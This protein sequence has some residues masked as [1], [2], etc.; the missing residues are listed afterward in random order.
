MDAGDTI[1]LDAASTGPLPAR[2]VAA[3]TEFTRR[4][5]TPHLISYEDQFQTLDRCRA[6]IARLIGAATDEIALAPNTGAGINLAAWGLPLGPGDEVVVPDGEFPANMYPWL[7]AARARGFSVVVVPQRDGLL[8]E[9]ALVAALDRPSVR[10]LAVSWVSFATGFAADLDHLGHACRARGV[11]L[12]VDAIQGLGAL[13]LDVTRT[14]IDLLACGAQKWLLSPWGT[15][16]IWMRRDLL[17]RI[18]PQPVSWMAVRSADDFSRL[19]D[20][21]LTWRDSAR[22]FE[23]VTMAYQ[24][25]AGMA[26]SLEL[27][28]E[29]GSRAVAKQVN[30]SAR[31]LIEGAGAVG[32]PVITPLERSA[33]IAS[34]RPSNPAGASAALR[35][36]G[37]IHSLREGTL[38]LAPHAFTSDEDIRTT[39]TMLHRHGA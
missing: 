3:E 30:R 14:P 28:H 21:D 38:R 12:V 26:A 18:I 17:A 4:R 23:Q 22:R 25:F 24:A 33:G 36:S 1:Y 37:V 15:G 7:A 20:Y 19:L 34:I 2:S 13:T 6:G 31:R 11:L 39:L 10:V 35:A 32:I 5:A 16:F 29:L 27:L 8:D 9:A